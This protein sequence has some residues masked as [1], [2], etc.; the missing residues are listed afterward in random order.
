[1]ITVRQ[2]RDALRSRQEIRKK[3]KEE[4]RELQKKR[5]LSVVDKT[6]ASHYCKSKK[7]APKTVTPW[8]GL[9]EYQLLALLC[10]LVVLLSRLYV[11]ATE[12]EVRTEVLKTLFTCLCLGFI[13]LPAYP[14][15]KFWRRRWYEVQRCRRVGEE[16]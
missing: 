11:K 10:L 2:L 8:K 1:M 7:Q 16:D 14:G 15:H 12:T 9:M 4:L 5:G 3:R 13:W 6:P